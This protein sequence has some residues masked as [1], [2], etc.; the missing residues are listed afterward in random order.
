MNAEENYANARFVLEWEEIQDRNT[1]KLLFFYFIKFFF[2]F[3]LGKVISVCFCFYFINSNW[4]Q[5][6]CSSA[7]RTILVFSIILKFR[8]SSFI[9]DPVLT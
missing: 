3:I 5:S 6:K 2:S 4:S 1:G 9:L 8:V 7:T